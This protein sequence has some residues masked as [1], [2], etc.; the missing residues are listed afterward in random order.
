[1]AGEAATYGQA[2]APGGTP[3]PLPGASYAGVGAWP[4]RDPYEM[5]R[6]V[7]PETY[8]PPAPDPRVMPPMAGVQPILSRDDVHRLQAAL[9]ELG[10]CRRLLNDVVEKKEPEEAPGTAGKAT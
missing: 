6:M 3:L 1:M 2:P 8:A 5:S 7:R 9:Y 4:V 10:E